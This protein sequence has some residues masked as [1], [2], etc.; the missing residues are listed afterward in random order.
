MAKI[1]CPECGKKIDN[2]LTT[3]PHCGYPLSEEERRATQN[4]QNTKS[5]TAKDG[6]A[7]D[8]IQNIKENY[9]SYLLGAIAIVAAIFVWD[10]IEN[11]ISSLFSTQSDSDVQTTPSSSNISISGVWGIEMEDGTYSKFTVM[12]DGRC[13]ITN[14][15][16]EVEY[17]G[18]AHPF[19]QTAF[20]IYSESQVNL[21]GTFWGRILS[22]SVQKGTQRT[23]IDLKTWSFVFDISEMRAYIGSATE[24]QNRDIGEIYYSRLKKF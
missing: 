6:M 10:I 14:N 24:Y 4:N 12:S 1:K 11:G 13:T 19:S 15:I 21:H 5:S 2:S 20:T 18:D 7:G 8:W 22:Y 23:W 9:K 3:C 17:I 16:G